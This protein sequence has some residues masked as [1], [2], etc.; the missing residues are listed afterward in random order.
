MKKTLKT[1]KSENIA[2]WA[3]EKE[4]IHTSIPIYLSLAMIKF[5]PRFFLNFLI[6]VIS[7][8]FF[9]FSKRARTECLRYQK[10][11]NS[12]LN[13]SNKRPKVFEQILSFAITVMEKIECWVKKETTVKVNFCNDDVNDLITHLNSGKPAFIMCS[14]L[15]NFEVFRN[16]ANHDKIYT[17]RKIPIS[18]LM[19]LGSTSNFTNT[20]KKINPEFSDNVIDVNSINPGTMEILQQTVDAGGMIIIAGDRI[21]KNANAKYLTAPFMGKDAPWS[22][23]AY[24]MAMLLKVPVYFIYG[25]RKKD[26][27]FDRNYDFHVVKSK[28]NT[29]CPRK[30]R[31]TKIKELCLE[32][33][34]ELE[35]QCLKHSLQWY[36]FFNFWGFPDKEVE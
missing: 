16:L 18:V 33:A 31:E 19:D 3:A 30:E 2:E 24:L 36:N 7:F 4:V 1:D 15:G 29:D 23:G 28:V 20:I 25:L 11:I 12:Y 26:T 22:Y 5:A 10:Q 8:F 17:D 6:R 21:S 32:F 14:H 27:G 9:L 35:K 13:Q 34:E